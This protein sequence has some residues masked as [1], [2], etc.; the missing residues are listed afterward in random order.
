MGL[1]Y[2]FSFGLPFSIIVWRFI[3][4][5]ASISNSFLLIEEYS[6]LCIHYSL[7]IHLLI[8]FWLLQL[9]LWW[10]FICVH[11]L[12]LTLGKYL[13]VKWFDCMIGIL[14]RFDFFF[15]KHLNS[16]PE[17]LYQRDTFYEMLH[18][19]NLATL[20]SLASGFGAI[21]ELI[22]VAESQVT[23]Y[24]Y[25]VKMCIL[26]RSLGSGSDEH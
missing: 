15:K 13:G 6:I 25:W 16:F 23:F 9:K 4:V 20:W 24:T 21:W 8:D 7:S 19:Y 11:L 26:K 3:H 17:C 2:T 1:Q 10:T 5:I 14:K 18:S 12:S 22:K